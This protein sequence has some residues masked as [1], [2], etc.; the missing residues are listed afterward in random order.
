MPETTE[1][2]SAIAC[3]DAPVLETLTDMNLNTL[4]RSGLDL[5]TYFMVRI[6]AL[7]AM[8]APPVAYAV[9]V[10]EAIEYMEWHDIE[11]ILVAIA[12]V[13]GSARTAAAA[14]NILDTFFDDEITLEEDADAVDGRISMQLESETAEYLAEQYADEAYADDRELEAV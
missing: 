11:A 7:V 4:E 8:D 2:L 12:P 3:G 5:K 14:S 13:V 10:D 1:T 9:N 6:A